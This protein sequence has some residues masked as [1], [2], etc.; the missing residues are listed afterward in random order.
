MAESNNV[1]TLLLALDVLQK[2]SVEKRK[3]DAQELL[4]LRQ[5]AS[6]PQEKALQDDELAC[7]IVHRELARRAQTS[8]SGTATRVA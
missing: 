2:F 1:T 4:Q 3:P 8:C 5:L 6:G 7:F